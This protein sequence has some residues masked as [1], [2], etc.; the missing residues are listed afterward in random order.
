MN[1]YTQADSDQKRQAE[2]R[3]VQMVLVNKSETCSPNLQN[4]LKTKVKMVGAI[5][6]EPMTS[7]V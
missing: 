2:G 4:L 7:T 6:F 3:I 1:L 5:G